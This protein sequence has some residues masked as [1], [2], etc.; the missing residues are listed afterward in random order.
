MFLLPFFEDS[1]L[2]SPPVRSREDYDVS[3]IF[4]HYVHVSWVSSD[5]EKGGIDNFGK[6]FLVIVK[7]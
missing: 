2:E 5:R 1:S 6:T 3:T 4:P 7:I